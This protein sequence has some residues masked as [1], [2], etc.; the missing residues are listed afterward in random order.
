M[1]GGPARL[2]FAVPA[3]KIGNLPKWQKTPGCEKNQEN[4]YILLDKR[5]TMGL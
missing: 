4:P 1:G 2:T 5:K 3:C